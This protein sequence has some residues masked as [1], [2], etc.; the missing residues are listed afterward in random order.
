[1]QP[2]IAVSAKAAA[3]LVSWLH[4]E[5]DEHASL[6]W[7]ATDKVDPPLAKSWEHLVLVMCKAQQASKAL[8]ALQDLSCMGA[9]PSKAVAEV[10]KA[11]VN[12][13]GGF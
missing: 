3:K 5:K 10:C 2:H 12:L 7:M 4:L 6:A 8:G 13:A 9:L 1:M 11:L